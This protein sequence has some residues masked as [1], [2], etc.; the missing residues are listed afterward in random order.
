M[1]YAS[2]GGVNDI[3]PVARIPTPTSNV[4][5]EWPSERTMRPPVPIATDTSNCRSR[6]NRSPRFPDTGLTTIPTTKSDANAPP[7]TLAESPFSACR[8][9]G[10]KLTAPAK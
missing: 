6:P 7:A 1:T 9:V 8:N 10:R 3:R 2:I 4:P 5:V